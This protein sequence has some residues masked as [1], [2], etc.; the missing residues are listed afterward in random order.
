MI[1]RFLNE[2]IIHTMDKQKLKDSSTFLKNF[3]DFESKS[4]SDTWDLA[5]QMNK[6]SILAASPVRF[7]IGKDWAVFGA[8]CGINQKL[9]QSIVFCF[10]QTAD[11]GTSRWVHLA[12]DDLTSSFLD[13]TKEN[14]AFLYRQIELGLK[15]LSTK[16]TMLDILNLMQDMRDGKTP[17]KC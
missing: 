4:P 10:I 1:A 7:V 14:K 9:F 17:W 15:L 6:F 8:V 12:N 5:S 16:K 2:A 3:P 11:D 13:G